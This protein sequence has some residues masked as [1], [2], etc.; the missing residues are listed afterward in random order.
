MDVL[1]KNK[2]KTTHSR[3]PPI[4]TEHACRE[5]EFAELGAHN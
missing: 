4:Q 1:K 2:E 3:V 5:N